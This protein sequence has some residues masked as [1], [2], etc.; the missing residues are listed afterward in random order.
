MRNIGV[1]P[2]RPAFANGHTRDRQG[3]LIG[4]LAPAPLPHPYGAGR[5]ITVLADR[6]RGKRLN[7]LTTLSVDRTARSGSAIHI[8]H[9]HRL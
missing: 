8:R 4:L 9:Q 1:S 2:P 5:R 6:Y 3:R 7:S